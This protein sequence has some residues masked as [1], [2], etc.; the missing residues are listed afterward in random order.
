M[1]AERDSLK[2]R[3]AAVNY[4]RLS[5]YWFPFRNADDSFRPG[6]TLDRIWERYVFDRHL[7]LLVMDAL[8]RIEIA[9]RTQLAYNHGHLHGPFGYATEVAA[10]PKLDESKRADFLQRVRDEAERSKERFVEHFTTK[11]GDEHHDLPIWMATEVMT[12]G[13]VLTLLRGSRHQVKKA[14]ASYFE[15]SATVFESWLVALNS[16]RN[17]CAHHGRLWNRELGTKPL[18]PR[19]S[20]YPAWHHP[21]EIGNERVFAVLTICK[22]CLDCL[23]L[24]NHWA[25]RLRSLLGDFPGVPI[26]Q[27]GFPE[28]WQSSP[29]WRDGADAA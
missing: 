5:G 2:R 16:V 11:Y 7:R 23:G 29:I 21:V 13:S 25:T 3:L 26:N 8:G 17:I 15:V 9:V 10:L 6:T 22:H 4:Y 18:I 27:M 14:V 24:N 28:G 1:V 19:A 12:F 20:E